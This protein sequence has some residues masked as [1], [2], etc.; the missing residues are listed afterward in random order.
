MII[1]TRIRRM[2]G[3]FSVC[4]LTPRPGGGTPVLLGG[5]VPPSLVRTGG[6][7]Y[8]VL[9]G[10]TPSQV[11][12]GYTHW[13]DGVPPIDTMGV[14]LPSAGWSTPHPGPR[15]GGVPQLEQH[16]MYLLRG[17]WYAS[18]VHAGGLPCLCIK[19]AMS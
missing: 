19:L 1:T 11:R 2:G 6:Y 17:A 10:G 12:M 3:L 7:P 8:P 18:C 9:I 16:S 5:G 14:A 13:Q 15:T 4:Q